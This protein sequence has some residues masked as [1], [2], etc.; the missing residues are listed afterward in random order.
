M[1]AIAGR[2]VVAGIVALLAARGEAAELKLRGEVRT[3]KSL[4][5]LGDVA[6]IYAAE[7]QEARSLAAVELMPAPA[8]GNR[9]F[10]RLRDIQ[11]LLAIRGINLAELQF[12]GA[13]QV[14]VISIAESAAKAATRRP[15][16][17]LL[18]QAQRLAAEAIVAHLHE[19]ASQDDWQVTVELESSQVQPIAAATE[20]IV[21]DGGKSPWLGSQRFKLTVPTAN[22][23]T[24]IEIAARVALPPAVVVAVHAVPRGTVVRAC[25]V[26]LQRLPPEKAAGE[27]YQNIAEVA[28]KEAAR[29]IA[30]RTNARSE[31]RPSAA[32]GSGRRSG[33]RVRPQRGDRG[34][35]ARRQGARQR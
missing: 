17:V 12:T 21:A 1:K 19:A 26:E 24:H 33:D 29:N 34:T 4:L 31:R 23:Q 35:N 6:D 18:L 10:V 16:K 15:A 3:Q 22:G 9:Q 20:T 14:L 5:L 2:I 7:P 25:D 8:S 27:A 13:S 32:A 28:G 11:D 30:R